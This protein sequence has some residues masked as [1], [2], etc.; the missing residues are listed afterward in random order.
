MLAF[1][2]TISVAMN[3]PRDYDEYDLFLLNSPKLEKYGLTRDIIGSPEKLCRKLNGFPC[4]KNCITFT[5]VCD[6]KVSKFY[7]N[8][9][10]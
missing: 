8:T 1:V 7:S 3:V 2:A 10:M 9:P 6:N 4:Q 5:K